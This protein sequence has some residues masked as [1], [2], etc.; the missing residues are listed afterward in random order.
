MGHER[1][2]SCMSQLLQ[3]DNQTLIMVLTASMTP[4]AS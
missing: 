1:P 4:V 3:S 2:N